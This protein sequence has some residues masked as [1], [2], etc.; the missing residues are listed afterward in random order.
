M[1]VDHNVFI[2]GRPSYGCTTTMIYYLSNYCCT[3]TMNQTIVLYLL[4]TID[5]CTVLVLTAL[6]LFETLLA[7]TTSS[8]WAAISTALAFLFLVFFAEGARHHLPVLRVLG[9]LLQQVRVHLRLET[10][11]D[12]LQHLVA[13]HII[14]TYAT[15]FCSCFWCIVCNRA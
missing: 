3:T 15:I 13:L 2:A 1:H 11:L 8:S 14:N 12:L 10:Q 5:P 7:G 9:P 4:G 6:P